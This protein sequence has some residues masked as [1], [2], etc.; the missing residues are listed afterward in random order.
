MDN[1]IYTASPLQAFSGLIFPIICFFVVGLLGTLYGTLSKRDHILFRL[2]VGSAGMVSLIAGVVMAITAY[3]S[4]QIGDRSVVLQVERVYD[5]RGI[6]GTD[7][8]VEGMAD[9]KYYTFIMGKATWDQIFVN[10]CYQFTYYPSTSLP[11]KYIRVPAYPDIKEYIDTLT[12]I[13]HVN[14]L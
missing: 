1:V 2:G 3:R 12:R 11:G 14:C 9:Q 13:E 8:V 10:D 7:Y 5:I 4:Y 6:T